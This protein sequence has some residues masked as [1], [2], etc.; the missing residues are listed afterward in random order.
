M[1][2]HALCKFARHAADAHAGCRTATASMPSPAQ[3]GHH[4]FDIALPEERI[5]IE[6]D[7]PYHYTG[8]PGFVLHF[9]LHCGAALCARSQSWQAL[10]ALLLNGSCSTEWQLLHPVPRTLCAAVN[11]L[12]GRH[13]P[14][15]RTA[16]RN[17]LICAQGWRLVVL[18]CWT[19]QHLAGGKE[20]QAW[21]LQKLAAAPR[22]C[23]AGCAD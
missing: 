22:E 21:L 6:V 17:R 13:W 16:A 3:G 5:A 12:H 9:V 8:A 15:G 19:W 7:G 10:P 11:K 4:S 2:L 18:D 20:R 23:A 14:L 1:W